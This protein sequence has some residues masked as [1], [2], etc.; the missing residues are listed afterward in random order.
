[1]RLDMELGKAGLVHL[2]SRKIL[3]CPFPTSLSFIGA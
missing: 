1:M 2:D 3:E